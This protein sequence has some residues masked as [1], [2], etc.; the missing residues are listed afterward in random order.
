METDMEPGIQ[1]LRLATPPD[2][3]AAA[4]NPFPLNI[5]GLYADPLL[6]GLALSV[7]SGVARNCEAVCKLQSQWWGVDALRTPSE[8][9]A[10]SRA[11][12]EADMIWWAIHADQELPEPAA[13]WADWLV[14]HQS[15][16]EGALV[17]LL[18]CPRDYVIRRSPSWH[19]LHQLARTAGME[20]FFERFVQDQALLAKV[21]LPALQTNVWLPAEGDTGRGQTHWG[22]NE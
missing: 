2:A 14:A 19:Y 4:E 16:T 20:F 22:I 11:A 9:E 1:R 5:V 15:K 6:H 13:V 12:T 3:G 17:A 21:P 7:L 10:A 8:R 18:S